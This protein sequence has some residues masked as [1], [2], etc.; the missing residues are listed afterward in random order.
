MCTVTLLTGIYQKPGRVF[1]TS[2]GPL[3]HSD[4]IRTPGQ[5]FETQTQ[6]HLSKSATVVS[7]IWARRLFWG[8]EPIHNVPS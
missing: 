4:A 8:L 6:T 7:P 3:K 5:V 2:A 1:E